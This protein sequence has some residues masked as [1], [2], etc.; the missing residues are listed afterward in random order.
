MK[1]S[2]SL[3]IILSLLFLGAALASAHTGGSYDLSW[4][5]IDGGGGVITGGDYRLTGSVGQAD[6]NSTLTGG[7]YTVIGGFLVG[8]ES[9]VDVDGGVTIY[10][11]LV[12]KS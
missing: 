10:L 2:I 12:I 4:S 8:G 7:D 6:A 3:F 5:T 11:P 9:F 1:T